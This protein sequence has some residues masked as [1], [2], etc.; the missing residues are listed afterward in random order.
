MRQLR[1]ELREIHPAAAAKRSADF[2][3]VQLQRFF[4][5]APLRAL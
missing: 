4:E 1:W 3:V 5:G 2:T